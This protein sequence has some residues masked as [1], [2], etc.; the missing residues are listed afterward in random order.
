MSTENETKVKRGRPKRVFASEEEKTVYQR[1][2][3]K[4]KCD[5]YREKMGLAFK[6]KHRLDMRMRRRKLAEEQGRELTPH[7]MMFSEDGTTKLVY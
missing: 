1:A 5:K 4:K 2:I 7:R 3:N 6:A